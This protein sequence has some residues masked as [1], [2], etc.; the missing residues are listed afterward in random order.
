M[1]DN[2]NPAFLFSST[3]TELLCK[4]VNGEI[5]PKQLA[6]KELEN[7]GLDKNGFWIGFKKK[8]KNN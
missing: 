6:E 4:I 8:L 1:Q 3:Y 7:R 5:D 2:L